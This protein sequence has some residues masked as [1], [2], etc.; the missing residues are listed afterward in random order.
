MYPLASAQ[1][2]VDKLVNVKRDVVLYVV[3]DTTGYLTIRNSSIVNKTLHQFISRQ[4]HVG[5]EIKGTS[6]PVQER[7]KA[8][9]ATLAEFTGDKSYTNNEQISSLS[10]SCDTP[11][12]LK[13][14]LELRQTFAKGAKGAF[15][16]LRADG[17]PMRKYSEGRRDHWFHSE[18][19]GLSVA[20]PTRMPATR[21]RPQEAHHADSHKTTISS[22]DPSSPE[23]AK[24]A[25]SLRKTNALSNPAVDK[26]IIKGSMARVAAT[27]SVLPLSRIV[28]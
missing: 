26:T 7:M 17:R 16:P 18:E 10:F 4:P 3:K 2:L 23:T 21:R 25:R 6:A 20:D 15:S 11:E 8:A 22:T 28:M 9:L 14:K 19:N 24:D 13:T 12:V 1:E 27:T 5:T